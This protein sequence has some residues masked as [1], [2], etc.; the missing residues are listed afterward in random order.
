MNCVGLILI[1]V[2]KTNILLYI[3]ILFRILLILFKR[4]FLYV[5]FIS[6]NK[7]KKIDKKKKLVLTDKCREFIL[8]NLYTFYLIRFLYIF[9]PFYKHFVIWY[10]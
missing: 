8:L 6:E 4:I 3:Y 9:L 7:H 10:W 5:C 1:L 2:F